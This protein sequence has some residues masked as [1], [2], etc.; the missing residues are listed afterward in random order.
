[1]TDQIMTGKA[2]TGKAQVS[3]RLTP[4]QWKHCHK[5]LNTRLAELAETHFYPSQAEHIAAQLVLNSRLSA[6]DRV[7]SLALLLA[8]SAVIKRGRLTSAEVHEFLS[9]NRRMEDDPAG[10]IL[11]RCKQRLIILALRGCRRRGEW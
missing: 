5:A 2:T 1:M 6:R 9:S 4:T 10:R 11:E 7:R 8:C 3:K